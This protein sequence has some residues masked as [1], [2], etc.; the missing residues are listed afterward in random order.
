MSDWND[1][2]Q[3]EE[4][5]PELVF[6]NQVKIGRRVTIAFVVAGLDLLLMIVLFTLLLL[7]PGNQS[8]MP[9]VLGGF[10]VIGVFGIGYGIYLLRSPVQVVVS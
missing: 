10:G 3:S 6:E 4:E 7:T 9:G 5:T 1:F 2:E 8:G